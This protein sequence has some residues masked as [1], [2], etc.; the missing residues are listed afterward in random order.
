M[1]F[2]EAV[3]PY[4]IFHSTSAGESGSQHT[5]E[6]STNKTQST[7]LDY[8]VEGQS[9]E[10]QDREATDTESDTNENQQVRKSNREH[11]TPAWHSDYY[12]S[13]NQI[14]KVGNVSVSP[15][16][17]CFMAKV[18]TNEDPK[19][20][21][22]AIQH[23]QWLE[24]MNEELTAL[25]NNNTWEITDLP[26]GKHAI[27]C[28]WLYTT[29]YDP[30]RNSTRYKSRLVVLG[31][32]QRY[33]IDYE[34]TLAPVAKLTTVRSLLA[35]AAMQG[36][37][38]HQMDVKNA[39]LHG[40]LKEEVYMRLPPGY[41]GEGFRFDLTPDKNHFVDTQPNVKV[42]RLIKTLY[43]L[44]Q[45]PSEWFDKLSSVL[46]RVDFIQSN[47]DSSLFI[48]QKDGVFTAIL[49]YVD[50]LILTGNNLEAIEDAK[51][52]LN[53]Q[54]KMKD[55]GELRYFLG[56]E[57][58]GSSKGIFLSQRKYTT[59]L[60]KEYNLLD[61]KPLRLPMDTHVKLL[62]SAGNPLPHPED[63]QR[64]VGKLIYLTFTRPDIAFTV[65]VL[66]QFMHSPTSVHFQ[67]AKRV[68][69]YLDGS[70]EQGILLA[71]D[72]V[73]ELQA[74]CDSD[75]AG[76]PNTRKST[77]GFCL[78]LGQSPITWKSKK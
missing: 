23:S 10:D 8:D 41:K 5:I 36:W 50:D 61:C 64:I 6:A 62:S 67:A 73:A 59:D 18:N 60:L 4:H 11:R 17:S 30:Q 25:E 35:V 31:N 51:Q 49:A 21:K 45:A 20:F 52:F 58:D 13:A 70:R 38:T 32:R 66:S 74:Y 22:E 12:M 29:K 44:K 68:L 57:V 48:K 71:S 33:G 76:C 63:Y 1:K 43:G 15:Q 24:A 78:L 47:A 40:E 72:S 56:I 46:K 16:F 65:H 37:Y 42:C 9:T 14:Q 19:H 75:W 77:S 27:G 26:P 34:Q 7:W 54:F 55:L 69:R 53:S 2:Y 39:F 3:Y 28:K